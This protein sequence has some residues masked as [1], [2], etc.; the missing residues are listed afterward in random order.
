MLITGGSGYLGGWVVRL[1]CRTW[2][3]TA[4]Y[5]TDPS[6]TA[7][8]DWRRL[9]VRHRSS[10]EALVGD[11]R[12]SVIIHTAALNPGR[13]TDFQAV[14]VEGT[15]HLADA[16]AAVGARLIHVSTDVLF[17]GQKGN[18]TEA[19]PPSPIT[20][21]GRSK[22][23]AEAAV[24][25]SG[26]EAVILRTS[27]IYGPAANAPEGAP[28]DGRWRHWDRQTRW[29]LGDLRAGRAVRLFTDERRC[30]IWVKSLAS[31]LVELADHPYAGVLHVAGP[32]A[33][34]RRRP[35][36][37]HPRAEPCERHDSSPRL[38]PRF[39]SRPH[40]AAHAPPRHRRDPEDIS[41]PLT[42]RW[43]RLP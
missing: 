20:P 29:I 19:D 4:T 1:A 38:H 16:A 15:R 24:R 41:I 12:P 17:D 28:S 18:Y 39:L 33:L 21:Y 27:L 36:R 42:L 40:H 25:V 30:P 32:Q 43:D 14:N 9:D 5:L 22:A 13:A 6:H 2:D 37:H 31:A 3:V 8:V 26:A 23:L 11:V 7:N 35:R 34:P 10:V